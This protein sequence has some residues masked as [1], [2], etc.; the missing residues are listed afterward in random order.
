MQGQAAALRLRAKRRTLSDVDSSIA[1]HTNRWL[2]WRDLA[3]RVRPSYSLS[4]WPPGMYRSWLD[5]R[6]AQFTVQVADVCGRI[7]EMQERASAYGTVDSDEEFESCVST[8]LSLEQSFEQTFASAPADWLPVKGC[9]QSRSALQ[10]RIPPHI[11]ANRECPIIN[12]KVGKQ[13][14]IGKRYSFGEDYNDGPFYPRVDTYPSQQ[15]GFIWSFMRA[16]RLHLLRAMIDLCL[17]AEQRENPSSCNLPSFGDIRTRISDTIHDICAALPYLLGDFYA[18]MPGTS[19]SPHL[20]T[21][22]MSPS[23]SAAIVMWLLHKVLA[24]P[25]VSSAIRAWALKVFER[26][27]TVGNIRHGLNLKRLYSQDHP[28]LGTN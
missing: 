18:G 3:H 25:G 16:A 11:L 17:I 23:G 19:P 21:S 4:D 14:N 10:D 27:G 20:Y 24:V 1:S 15:V 28:M 7:Q 6:A 8:A 26:L 13:D 5:E 12:W 2:M 9:A 22:D